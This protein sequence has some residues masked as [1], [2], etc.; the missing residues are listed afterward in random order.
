MTERRTH[1]RRRTASKSTSG[2]E[3]VWLGR[4]WAMIARPAFIGVV[5]VVAGVVVA[6]APTAT[7]P[8]TPSQG[9]WIAAYRFT[10]AAQGAVTL[11]TA[12]LFLAAA[13]GWQAAQSRRRQRRA[14]LAALA[15]MITGVSLGLLTWFFAQADV[16]T[17]RVAVAPGQTIEAYPAI[18][19]GRAFKVMLPSRIF[20]TSVDVDAGRASIEL[21]KPGAD[22]GLPNDVFVGDPLEIAG[23][24]FALVGMELDPR[25]R[26]AVLTMD[27]G[28]ERRAS[29]RSKIRFT[30][31]GP[32]YEVKSIVAD[33]LGVM[34]PAVELVGP[35][36][37]V[38]WVTQRDGAL[39]RPLTKIRL[40]RLEAAPVPVFALAKTDAGSVAPVAALI[41]VLG[42]GLLLFARDRRE[43]DPTDDAAPE[44]T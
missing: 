13:V 22:T 36:D 23:V 2:D 14:P 41:F 19:S 37:D 27:G 29:V 6:L 24:R 10:N 5:L 35:D 7:V 26:S 1:S 34:G 40:S 44:E 42:L 28:I 8:S 31:D 43:P 4:L 21:R 39:E 30:P 12:A 25:I 15:L 9:W 33:F 3:H 38:F 32:E 20:I 17:S 18:E 11:L 16:P